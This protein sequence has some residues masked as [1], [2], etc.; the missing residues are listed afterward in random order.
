MLQGTTEAACPEPHF[1]KLAAQP[2]LACSAAPRAAAGAAAG[3]VTNWI[4]LWVGLG[5]LTA[6]VYPCS[7]DIEPPVSTPQ[8]RRGLPEA[9]GQ[10]RHF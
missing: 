4:Y 6:Q 7:V 2:A 3:E 9:T 5:H 1:W 10:N 8:G